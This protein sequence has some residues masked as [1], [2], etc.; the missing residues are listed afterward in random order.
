MI[1]SILSGAGLLQR[2][3]V[4]VMMNLSNN[5]LFLILCEPSFCSEEFPDHETKGFWAVGREEVVF[6]RH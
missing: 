2:N 6:K 3:Q 5:D 1:T 4:F